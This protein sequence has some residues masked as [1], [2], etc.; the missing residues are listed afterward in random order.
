MLFRERLWPEEMSFLLTPELLPRVWWTA[1]PA[2]SLTL[3][4]WVGGPRAAGLLGLARGSCREGG[5]V[6]G[7][8]QRRWG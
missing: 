8:G 7:C 6:R 2:E 4:G 1:H 3:T 5:A